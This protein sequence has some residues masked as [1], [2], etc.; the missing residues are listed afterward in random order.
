M[1]SQAEQHNIQLLNRQIEISEWTYS[2]RMET[3]FVFQVIFIAL[4]IVAILLYLRGS[5]MAGGGFVWY[6]I[7]LLMFV[8]I[9]IIVNRSMYTN[10]IRDKRA[11]NRRDFSQDNTMVS[12]VKPGDEEYQKYIDAIRGRYGATPADAC[13]ACKAQNN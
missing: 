3:L 12:P 10:K 5:G 6:A 1:S 7:A 4:M 2:D 13:A 8:V 9:L 11:W